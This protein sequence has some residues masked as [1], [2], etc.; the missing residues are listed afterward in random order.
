MKTFTRFS[1]FLMFV[2]FSIS[3][4]AVNDNVEKEGAFDPLHP[5]A[6]KFRVASE[7]IGFISA[8]C[9]THSK[10]VVVNPTLYPQVRI[11]Y[12]AWGGISSWHFANRGQYEAETNIPTRR[13]KI[14]PLD[15]IGKWSDSSVVSRELDI[16]M[17][18]PDVNECEAHAKI[19]DSGF[20]SEAKIPFP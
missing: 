20:T 2:I 9:Y 10:A 17:G 19:N 6:G 13:D 15:Y 4:L 3:V 16:W 8:S 11:S 7:W 5:N 14:F 18:S 12:H 1:I